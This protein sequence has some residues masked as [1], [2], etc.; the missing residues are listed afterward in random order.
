[1][2]SPIKRALAAAILAAV[3]LVATAA[4]AAESPA[5]IHT[6]SLRPGASA[7]ASAPFELGASRKPA[8]VALALKSESPPFDFPAPDPSACARCDFRSWYSPPPFLL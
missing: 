4:S 8:P 7:P 5:A 6:A 2:T 3:S 1:M